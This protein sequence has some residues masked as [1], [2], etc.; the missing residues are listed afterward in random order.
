MNKK[1]LFFVCLSLFGSYDL[2]SQGCPSSN[3]YLDSA[4]AAYRRQ[5]F[6][7]FKGPVLAAHLPGNVKHPP[8]ISA[9]AVPE[10]FRLVSKILS[11][12]DGMRVYIAAYAPTKNAD[13]N[14]YAT[15]HQNI[16]VPIFVPTL[17]DENGFHQDQPYY[18]IIDMDGLSMQSI[19][20]STARG[21]VNNYVNHIYNDLSNAL[22]KSHLG[23]DTRHLWYRGSDL[24]TLIEDINCQIAEHKPIT[25]L[26]ISWGLFD[27]DF[28]P[29]GSVPP[30]SVLGQ[31]TLVFDIPG[32]TVLSKQ[33]KAALIKRL[34]LAN[35]SRH[36]ADYDTGV[37]CPPGQN[38]DPG[39]SL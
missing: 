30:M 11:H 5:L 39:P 28:S 12:G 37:P 25:N 19:D 10:F 6:T 14:V 2:F 9:I 23:S 18:Y 38:C 3:M 36:F 21:W 29:G 34:N 35:K 16:L 15:G 33:E 22:P 24:T 7:T 31:I 20:V 13:D 4:I 17:D 26:N 27:A 8:G 1:I 32:S